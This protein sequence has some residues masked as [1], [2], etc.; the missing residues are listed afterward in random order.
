MFSDTEFC[1]GQVAWFY[2]DIN[3][4]MQREIA[5]NEDSTLM[6][7]ASERGTL[8]NVFGLPGAQ[9][10]FTLRRGTT[11]ATIYSMAFSP[12]SMYPPLLS[13]SGSHGTIHIFKLGES[14]W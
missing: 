6:A 8:V 7:T 11:S 1:L 3:L 5:L 12:V 14:G 9:K 13:V 4:A 2:K 10:L